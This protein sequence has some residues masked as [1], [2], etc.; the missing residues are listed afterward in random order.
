[1]NDTI[2]P[3]V[4][5]CCVMTQQKVSAHVKTVETILCIAPYK[6]ICLS[7]MIVRHYEIAWIVTKKRVKT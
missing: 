5:N 4:L 7:E 6:R 2:E 3:D 1:M